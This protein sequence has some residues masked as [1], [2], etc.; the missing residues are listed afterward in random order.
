[1]KILIV[2]AGAT[3]TVFAAALARAGCDISFYVRPHHRERLTAGLHLYHQGYFAVREERLSGFGVV[4][5]TQQVA[6]GNWDQVWFTTP[7][8][9]LRGDWLPPFLAAC[10][11]ATLVV[12]QPDPE[13]IQ[14]VRD[15]GGADRHIIQGIIQFSAWQSP[16]PHEPADQQG[17]TCLMPPGPHALF[18][19]ESAAS[20]TVAATLTRGGL[21]AGTRKDLAAYAARMS[22][23][24]IPLV[25]GLE[26]AGWQLDRYARHDALPLAMAAAREAVAAECAR[27]SVPVPLAF[28]AL[29][30]QATG[31]AVLR[32]LPWVPGFKAEAFL[33]WHFGKVDR[34]T[35]QMLDTYLRH[36]R[37]NGLPCGALEQLRGALPPPRH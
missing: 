16:Q 2:G 15:N 5:D 19:E 1:M 27:F 30:N 33:Q 28:R 10:G 34:Q 24:M 22:A 6:A 36:A 4:T 7:S 31:R 8:D 37:Q 20:A 32:A 18:D 9:A 12:L 14:Y 35:R 23:T 21:N 3:G 13:D 17:I 29:L 26:L 11:Q 25:A